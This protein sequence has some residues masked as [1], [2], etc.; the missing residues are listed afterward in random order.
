[1]GTHQHDKVWG[2]SPLENHSVAGMWRLSQGQGSLITAPYTGWQRLQES[3]LNS[4][5][6]KNHKQTGLKGTLG[7]D[8]D[9]RK[10]PW[11]LL[12]SVTQ[13]ADLKRV[14]TAAV[15]GLFWR[16]HFLQGYS[17]PCQHRLSPFSLWVPSLPSKKGREGEKK[18]CFSSFYITRIQSA[19]STIRQ[20]PPP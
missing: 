3:R 11:K 2:Y 5:G 12:G 7:S 18:S 20:T 6:G 1:M 19:L 9:A 14:E 15:P 10:R 17:R 13:R 8:A 16:L 4:Q